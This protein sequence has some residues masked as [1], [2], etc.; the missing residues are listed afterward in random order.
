MLPKLENKTQTETI[1]YIVLLI[2]NCST[3]VYNIYTVYNK[4]MHMPD[5]ILRANRAR[6]VRPYRN[7]GE[8]RTRIGHVQHTINAFMSAFYF[9][10]S[11]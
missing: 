1:V 9:E 3:N 10:K 4:I 2:I 6:A 11:C 8:Y 5:K 7:T